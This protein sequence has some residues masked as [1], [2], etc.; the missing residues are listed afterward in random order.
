MVKFPMRCFE[1]YD[2]GKFIR[3]RD[4]W[5]RRGRVALSRL[6][7]GSTRTSRGCR[8]NF[9][10]PCLFQF[11]DPV[12]RRYVR[13]HAKFQKK[14]RTHAQPPI[15]RNLYS[16]TLLASLMSID[17]CETLTLLVVRSEI[18]MFN[19]NVFPFFLPLSQPAKINSR[20]SKFAH[21]T[22]VNKISPHYYIYISEILF[23][24]VSSKK[25]DERR[26]RKRGVKKRNADNQRRRETSN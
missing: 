15:Y 8:V 23:D 16:V 1:I 4:N 11:P 24:C 20:Q 18:W 3:I 25:M 22:T 6:G 17:S 9:P 12:S 14:Q 26:K 19:E 5:K 10:R 7:N 2:S 13:A 21:D